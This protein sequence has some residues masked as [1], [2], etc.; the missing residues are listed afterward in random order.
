MHDENCVVLA[1]QAVARVPLASERLA[2][3]FLV[4]T[5]SQTKEK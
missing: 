2:V 5:A 1:F 3:T 4:S